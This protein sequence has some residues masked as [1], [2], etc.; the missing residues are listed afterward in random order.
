MRRQSTSCERTPR[1]VDEGPT[2]RRPRRPAP[3]RSR[4]PAF[5]LLELAVS[6]IVMAA[7]LLA[8]QTLMIRQS[9]QISRLERWCRPTPTYY[10]VNQ[11]DT[12]MRALCAPANLDKT[13]G[14]SAWTPPVPGPF[15][16]DVTMDSI[17]SSADGQQMSANAWVYKKQ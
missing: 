7:G 9:K 16:Y 6:L 5:T 10:V 8:I 14:Q 13:A 2:H 4:R 17:T 15:D 3:A 12:W 11:S 1:P